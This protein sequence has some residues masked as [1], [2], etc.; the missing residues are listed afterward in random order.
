MTDGETNE[1]LDACKETVQRLDEENDQL[2]QAA[3]AFGQLAERL[4]QRLRKE[5]RLGDDRRTISRPSA[6]RRATNC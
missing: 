6:D 2:R 5:R 3:G 4:N 1:E